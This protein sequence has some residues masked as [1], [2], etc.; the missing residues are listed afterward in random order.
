LNTAKELAH[1][2]GLD[3]FVLT[4]EYP[5]FQAVIT[6]AEDRALREE[7]YRAYITR[8]SDQGPGIEYQDLEGGLL[9]PWS[10]IHVFRIDLN[11]NQMALVTAKNL[12]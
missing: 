10:H 8:A 9:N 3:G 11:K 2:K 5:C 12:A 1:E 6:H 4:L 7:M